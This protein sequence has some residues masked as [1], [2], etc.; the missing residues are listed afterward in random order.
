MPELI[1]ANKET[2]DKSG[3]VVLIT[4][5]NAHYVGKP[6]DSMTK[7]GEKT[8]TLSPGFNWINESVMAGPGQMM[9]MRQ[10][11][12]LGPTLESSVIT[13]D[14]IG[15]QH[16][17][18]WDEDSKEEFFNH[19][20]NLMKGMEQQKRRRSLEKSNLVVA[21]PG[22]NPNVLKDLMSKK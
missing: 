18:H 13:I 10:P 1:N 7:E 8:I 19:I 11:T 22:V 21:Q 9:I 15:I 14:Y 6:V 3:W 12:P 20:D 16:I 5:S 17:D 4:A 2:F